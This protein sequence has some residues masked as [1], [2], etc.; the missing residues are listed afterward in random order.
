MVDPKSMSIAWENFA[1]QED[2]ARRQWANPSK[3]FPYCVFDDAL[4][5]DAARQAAKDFDTAPFAKGEIPR[6]EKHGFNK[7]GG[8]WDML[9][10]LQTE[11]VKAF[12][13]DEFVAYLGRVTGLRGL[14]ADPTLLGGGVHEILPGGYLNVHTDF[15]IHPKFKSLRALN[16]IVYLNEDWQDEW[17]GHLELWDEK[18]RHPIARFAPV[19]NRAVLFRTNEI[20]YH[21]HPKPLACPEGRTRR[22]FA[23]YYYLPWDKSLAARMN[24]NYQLV[25]WQWGKL[26]SEIANLIENRV[27]T[28]EGVTA[29]LIDR[30]QSDDIETAFNWI[31]SAR[32]WTLR[33]E[34]A[35][36][37]TRIELYT[38][39]PSEPQ[40]WRT[41]ELRA[42]DHLK[43]EGGLYISTG[44]DP[45]VTIPFE[46]PLHSVL[47]KL[48]VPPNAESDLPQL[49]FDFGEGTSA[50][51]QRA[52][53]AYTE[54]VHAFRLV[55]SRP[56]HALRID[57]FSRPCEAPDLDIQIAHT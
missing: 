43:I 54:G 7:R 10:P 4:P 6:V 17:E 2:A 16:L 37:E 26:A 28:L 39:D 1:A 14:Q 13:S 49:F 38:V 11:I 32:T 27:D 42:N 8:P 35:R 34:A 51:Y 21:G 41:P 31:T 45:F 30:W 24:T 12:N 15:N 19:I 36:A 20:S 40:D 33:P 18:V 9:S 46:K 29:A 47:F 57:P 48:R 56:L 52:L 50:S 22:S 5:L 25:P 55:S 53:P 44:N 3:P 23:L